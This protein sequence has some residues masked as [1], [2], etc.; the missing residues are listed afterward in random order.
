MFW[1]CGGAVSEA[2]GVDWVGLRAFFG[3]DYTDYT[4][5]LRA[6]LLGGQAFLIVVIWRG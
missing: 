1:G 4:D 5:F 2:V 3:T 6:V